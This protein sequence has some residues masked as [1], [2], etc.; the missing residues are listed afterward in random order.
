MR[1]TCFIL[2]L[3]FT[4]LSSLA[5]TNK[6]L[7]L[8]SAGMDAFLRNRKPPVLT[9]QV[10]NKPD[11]I[12]SV[13]IKCVFVGLGSEYQVTK[14]YTTNA[15]GKASIVLSDNLPFQQVW[16]SV[17]DWLYSGVYVN[18]QLD[19]LIDAA[20]ISDKDG[21]RFI[22]DGIS[23]SGIDGEL[24][25]VMSTG[26]VALQQSRQDF[27]DGILKLT[28][29]RKTYTSSDFLRKIDSLQAALFKSVSTFNEQYPKFAWATNNEIASLF[30]SELCIAYL[31][32]TMPGS[33][34]K[35]ISAHQPL[36]TSNDGSNYYRYLNGYETSGLPLLE[37][38]L[39]KIDRLFLGPKADI[40][41]ALMLNREKSKFASSYPV[42]A[43][44]IKT[45]WCKRIVNT[46]LADI[47][48]KQ[49]SI[50]KLLASTPRGRDTASFI[51]MP[52]EQLPYPARLYQLEN[53]QEIDKL[54]NNLQARFPHKALII[55]FWATWCA[56]CLMDLP[57][58]KRLHEM[59]KDLPIEYI[60]ICTNQQ[61]NTD[62]W[63]RNIV[64]LEVPGTHIYMDEKI[65]EALKTTFENAG[66][67]FPTYVVIDINGKLRP[68]A[69]QSMG[70]LD[71]E[72]LLQATGIQP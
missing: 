10:K 42:I 35:K 25:T 57:Y 43:H 52:L 47:T 36:F 26:F 12:Q 54:I 37:D 9:I 50:D 19:V 15:N 33:L 51:G 61:S 44:S 3:S 69:I 68:N 21:V 60:Y 65:V 27:Q 1:K 59:N 16:L 41:K 8:E 31:N 63:K 66:A 45:G 14:Y 38:R 7:P 22:G 72:K 23:Y 71:R 39:Q 28:S 17:G 6:P 48:Q 40:L 32:D 70:M 20:R 2:L 46:E 24:N 64:K 5:Q 13:Q 34:F 58:S 30:Y 49:R 55:D 62:T 11:S 29:T 4:A 18:K 53:N 67:G 56:P